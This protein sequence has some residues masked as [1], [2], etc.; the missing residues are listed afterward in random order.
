MDRVICEITDGCYARDAA[1]RHYTR[2]HNVDEAKGEEEIIRIASTAHRPISEF[3]SLLADWDVVNGL[4]RDL[5]LSTPFPN[6]ENAM[7]RGTF[8]EFTG[9]TSS[10]YLHAVYVSEA[11][12]DRYNFFLELNQQGFLNEGPEIILFNEEQAALGRALLSIE[13]KEKTRR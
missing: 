2:K 7:W 10:P 9:S 8:S 5:L 13:R 3:K 12:K 4:G 1:V 6:F 11:H